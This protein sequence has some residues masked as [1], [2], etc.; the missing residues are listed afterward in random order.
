MIPHQEAV[1]D[2]A[3]F[4][5]WDLKDIVG[6]V[7]RNAHAKPLKYALHIEAILAAHFWDS[8]MAHI[9]IFPIVFITS[10][11]ASHGFVK[12]Y[13]KFNSM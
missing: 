5:H 10:V 12:S 9:R 8:Y 4:E 13:A 11:L 7:F 3:A 1:N 6:G 2:K